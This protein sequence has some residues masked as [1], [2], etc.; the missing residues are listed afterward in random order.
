M[1]KYLF[2]KS[3]WYFLLVYSIIYAV[4]LACFA[5]FWRTTN[6]NH[7]LLELG[8][9]TFIY[10]FNF[11]L[12]LGTPSGIKNV[13]FGWVGYILITITALI[14]AFVFPTILNFFFLK[15]MRRRG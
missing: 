13:L 11:E 12:L 9:K 10:M 7:R 8:A 5:V 2:N 15:A 14:N 6:E 4:T 1:R 3:W